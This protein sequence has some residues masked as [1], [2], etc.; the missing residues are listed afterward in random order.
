MLESSLAARGQLRVP[1]VTAVS[2]V[3]MV[4]MAMTV[5]AAFRG[6]DDDCLR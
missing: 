4:M 1:V 5:S 3:V 6:W 2:P